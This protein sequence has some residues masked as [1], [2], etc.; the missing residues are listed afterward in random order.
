MDE[1][2]QFEGNGD[3]V[4][5]KSVLTVG[6]YHWYY[7]V[8]AMMLSIGVAFIVNRYTTKT[9]TVSAA[10]LLENQE[11]GT[12]GIEIFG[13]QGMAGYNPWDPTFINDKIA[14]FKSKEFLNSIIDSLN[15]DISYFAIGDFK[16]SEQYR[17]LPIRM[18]LLEADPKMYHISVLVHFLSKTNA[19][20]KFKDQTNDAVVFEQNIEFGRL[21]KNKFATFQ[22][23]FDQ[24]HKLPNVDY[25]VKYTTL[26]NQVKQISKNLFVKQV[27]DAKILELTMEHPN[28]DKAMDIVNA[29]CEGF[30][31]NGLKDK[32]QRFVNSLRFINDQLD[33]VE[34]NLSELEGSIE[35]FSSEKELVDLEA[36]AGALLTNRIEFEN[37][38]REQ[39]IY[40]ANVNALED[41][42][43]SNQNLSLLA[44]STFGITD[45]MLIPLITEVSELDAELRAMSE[46][47]SKNHIKYQ[48]TA[49]QLENTRQ[50]LL[51]NI[52]NH[53]SVVHRA[54]NTYDAKVNEIRSK[55]RAI[56]AWKRESVVLGRKFKVQENIYL[57]LLQKKFEYEIAQSGNI[58]DYE[59]LNRAEMRGSPK[60]DKKRNFMA[61]FVAGLLF[62]SLILF[63][64][65]YFDNKIRSRQQVENGTRAPFL[66]SIP[67]HQGNNQLVFE[68]NSKS[69]VAESFRNLR[70]SVNFM[71]DSR[72]AE[73]GT[74]K[75]VL[76][77]ST[78]SG[79]GKTFCAANLA[80][81]LALSDKTVIVLG[82]DL[83]KPRVH[84]TFDIRNDVGMSNYLSSRVELDEVIKHTGIKNID[85]IPSGP[86][87]PN[88]SEL[89]LNYRMQQCLDELRN[90]YDYILLDTAPIG[91]VTDPIALLKF[92]DLNVF[93]I[94]E[95]YSKV[96]TLDLINDLYIG[97]GIKNISVLINGST[98]SSIKYGYGSK[99]GGGYGGSYGYGYGQGNSSGYG[100]YS[101]AQPHNK[102]IFHWFKSLMGKNK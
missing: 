79:E 58:S 42:L 27:K 89:L 18:E 90:R 78:I 11:K 21:Y 37:L 48:T 33:Q 77:T 28:Q 66:A 14:M 64:K 57:L 93:V 75:V 88:P 84:H 102:G 43:T 95:N 56:P 85:L 99:Y 72:K 47:L 59:F 52:A 44:P 22:I 80:H 54:L 5:I 38:Y 45:P 41:Y 4:N 65:I 61:A 71:L 46:N 6:L 23:N 76:F 49:E 17:D 55:I 26:D 62:P 51:I 31:R 50:K 35:E 8:I 2:K 92:S 73:G 36:E 9:Y 101:D 19:E 13:G 68:V 83:R 94:R 39:R 30:I 25:E 98:Y 87:P 29:I 15:I 53:K 1:H 69:L 74:S 40:L 7:F 91:L 24:E 100:Y 20:I 16:K 67:F 10:I 63:F 86:V 12:E 96:A 82:L 81:V 3:G 70:S 97:Q 32:N 34:S 60:P